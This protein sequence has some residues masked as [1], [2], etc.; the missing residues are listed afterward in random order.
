MRLG[1]PS[2]Y[3][4][5]LESACAAGVEDRWNRQKKDLEIRQEGMLT[6]IF[7]IHLYAGLIRRIAATANLP[8]TCQTR[9]DGAIVF[10]VVAILR[11]FA[12][13]DWAWTYEGHVPTNDIDKLGQFID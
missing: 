12:F 4:R 11:N 7:D 13:N 3:S 2:F 5:P 1:M 10:E 6:N 8:K 9:T